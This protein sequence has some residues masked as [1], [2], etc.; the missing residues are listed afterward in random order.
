[1]VGKDWLDKGGSWD[2]AEG[3]VKAGLGE[4]GAGGRV[5]ADILSLLCKLGA[6]R[7]F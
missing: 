3:K 4:G 2:N 6:L 7:D 1:M 5:I